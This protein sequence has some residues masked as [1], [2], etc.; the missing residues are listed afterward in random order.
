MFNQD[1]VDKAI[2]HIA[3]NIINGAEQCPEIITALAELIRARAE[4]NKESFK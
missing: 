4:L 3:D 1:K 2:E